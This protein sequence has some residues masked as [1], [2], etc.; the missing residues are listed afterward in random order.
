MRIPKT[1]VPLLAKKIVDNILSKNLADTTVPR[2]KL[3]SETEGILMEELS[4]EDRLNDEVREILKTHAVEIE[5][6]R[7]DYR[8]LFDLTKQKL[9]RERNL[10]L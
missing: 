10:V 6:G 3:I 7:L 1:W 8:K 2:D 4:I 5:K 9:V